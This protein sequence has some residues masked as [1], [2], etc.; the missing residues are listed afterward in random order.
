M[1]KTLISSMA[2][3]MSACA[4]GSTVA[5][6]PPAADATTSYVVRLGTDTTAFEQYTRI[7]YRIESTISQRGPSTLTANSNIEMGPSGLPSSWRYETLLPTGA[8][9]ANGATVTWTFST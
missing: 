7:G 9:P 6:S 1:G 4:T 8:R 3:L 5:T 2:V